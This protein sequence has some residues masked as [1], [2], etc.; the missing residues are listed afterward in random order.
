MNDRFFF[1]HS[2]SFMYLYVFVRCCVTR[3]ELTEAVINDDGR[4]I[5]VQWEV[6]SAAGDMSSDFSK[7][8]GNKTGPRTWAIRRSDDW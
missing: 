7:D 1:L 8:M 3:V 6:L 4:F 5:C 2:F